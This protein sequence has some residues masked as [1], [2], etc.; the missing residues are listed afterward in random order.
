MWT[1]I[2][3]DHLSVC[4]LWL[5]LFSSMPCVGVKGSRI[6][7]EEGENH[8]PSVENLLWMRRCIKHLTCIIS[9]NPFLNIVMRHCHYAH[10]IDEDTEA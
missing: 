1:D 3:D 10:A 5:V 8:Q 6:G 7:G 2:S 9:F 4:W